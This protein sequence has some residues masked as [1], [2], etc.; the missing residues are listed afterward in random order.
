MVYVELSIVRRRLEP[1]NEG[2]EQSSEFRVQ[3]NSAPIWTAPL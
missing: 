2:R 1:V 3:K